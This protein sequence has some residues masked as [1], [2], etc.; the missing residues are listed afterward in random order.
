MLSPVKVNFCKAAKDE[1]LQGCEGID[2]GKDQRIFGLNPGEV[3]AVSV[4][5]GMRY[6]ISAYLVRIRLWRADRNLEK[7]ETIR[8]I[9][10]RIYSEAGP[11]DMEKG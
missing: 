5:E 2:T 6:G 9:I 11:T 8:Y 10:F 1:N 7:Q 4:F 3:S